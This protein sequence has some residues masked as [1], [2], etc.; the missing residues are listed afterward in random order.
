MKKKLTA[1]EKKERVDARKALTAAR[2][3][4]DTLMGKRRRV[5]RM[6]RFNP[7][8]RRWRMWDH[9][10]DTMIHGLARNPGV[11]SMKPEQV[12]KF[13]AECADAMSATQDARN[14]KRFESY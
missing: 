6:R 3:K 13:A 12:V 5:R 10:F 14:P 2:K 4:V 11:I 9:D 1:A 7:N 8:E